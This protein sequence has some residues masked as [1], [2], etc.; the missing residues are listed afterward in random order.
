MKKVKKIASV[1]LAIVMTFAMTTI[2]AFAATNDGKITITNAKANQTYTIYKIADL[3]S[4]DTTNNVY[5]YKVV[6][7]WKTWLNTNGYLTVDAAGEIKLA[8]GKGGDNSSDAADFAKAAL[9]FAKG[10]S[11]GI[12]ATATQTPT[13]DG[14]IE[15]T[16]LTLGYYLVDSSLGTVCSLNSTDKEIEMT[17]K[18][19]VP[20]I[21]AAT[22]AETATIGDTVTFTTTVAVPASGNDLVL[23]LA[24]TDGLTITAPA[25]DADGKYTVTTSGQT[26]TVTF[27]N[28][29]IAAG[30]VAVTLSAKVN[31]DILTQT[32]KT[33]TVSSKLTYGDNDTESTTET[34]S[35]TVYSFDLVN[36]TTDNTI[37]TTT[38]FEF[39]LYKKDGA[40]ID[41]V[42]EADGSYR[43]AEDG[44]TGVAIE[45]GN[46]TVKGLGAGDYTI[47][48]KNH[49]AGYVAAADKDFTISNADLSATLAADGKY[50]SGGVQIVYDAGAKLP[51]T[52]GIGTTIFYVAGITL[53]AGAF[54]LL[55]VKKRNRKEEAAE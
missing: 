50:Q 40:K 7:A 16:G 22:S 26:V 4:F 25:D 5:T 6:D 36:T 24:A 3:E 15:F 17:D 33:A 20:T 55:I 31:K 23:T 11:S 44:E 19:T 43:V 46:V 21:T 35:V 27:D 1:I 47:K 48:E 29:K 30:D 37:L 49:P 2:T 39:E 34:A 54:I 52:G 41:V 32:D 9:E 42:K 10:A 13:A 53:V 45:A 8:T 14:S 28:T 38:G 51:T 12:T 18:N